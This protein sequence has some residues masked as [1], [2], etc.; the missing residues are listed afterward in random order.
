MK[1]VAYDHIWSSAVAGDLTGKDWPFTGQKVRRRTTIESTWNKTHVR[2][3]DDEIYT[4]V[5]VLY[6][7]EA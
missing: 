2:M 3:H 7:R 1:A 5:T 6:Q 4:L